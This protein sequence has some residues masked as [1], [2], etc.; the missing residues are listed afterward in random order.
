MDFNNRPV[1]QIKDRLRLELNV[2]QTD[3]SRALAIKQELEHLDNP[4]GYKGIK[5]VTNR[6][7]SQTPNTGTVKSRNGTQRQA[8]TEL[9]PARSNSIADVTMETENAEGEMTQEM[10]E[11]NE[12]RLQEAMNQKPSVLLE[13]QKQLEPYLPEGVDKESAFF[14]AIGRGD[15]DRIAEFSKRGIIDVKYEPRM[16]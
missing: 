5:P 9:P 1:E 16:S 10:I 13:L 6:D 11:Q 4:H 7:G 14:K 3:S 12:K 15:L 8:Q 2:L